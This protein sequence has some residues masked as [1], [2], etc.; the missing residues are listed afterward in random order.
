M[1][2]FDRPKVDLKGELFNH[3]PWLEVY[4]LLLL[5][6]TFYL[7]FKQIDH[8]CNKTSLFSNLKSARIFLIHY[9][10]LVYWAVRVCSL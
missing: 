4:S 10:Y 2:D 3:V 1:K 6:T 7:K 8:V 9:I 5:V